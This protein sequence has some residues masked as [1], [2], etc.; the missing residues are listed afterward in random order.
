MLT[1]MRQNMVDQGLLDNRTRED[2]EETYQFYVPLKG[3]AAFPEGLEMKGGNGTQGF[4]IKGS[5][6]FKARGRVTL[7]VN[8]LTV[9]MKDAEEKIV[10]A[11]KN[12]T[13]QKLLKMFEK[14]QSPDN[15]RVYNQK[16]RPPRDSN[17]AEMKSNQEMRSERRPDD[18]LPRYI[19]V[20]RRGKSFFIEV[21]DRNS[22]AS[23]RAVVLA[24]STIKWTS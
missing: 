14:F 23:C 7:P 5:E 21:R 3:F 8:P 24:C 15:W 22:T 10:R 19:E 18:G 20:K 12:R 1:D 13:A 4:S 9:A 16:V 17:P 6:S 2:W 11:E